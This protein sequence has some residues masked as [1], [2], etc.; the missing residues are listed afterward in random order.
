AAPGG[1]SLSRHRQ[2]LAPAR[3]AVE[4]V[5][6]ALLKG[7]DP[8]PQKHEGCPRC[9]GAPAEPDFDQLLAVAAL[10][11]EEIHAAGGAPLGG[12]GPP[13]PQPHAR[14]RLMW[15]PACTRLVPAG[16]YP[17]S[18]RSIMH[19]GTT[20]PEDAPHG[21]LVNLRDQAL[22]KLVRLSTGHTE[23]EGRWLR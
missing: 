6:R 1:G 2:A 10:T 7:L 20:A 16:H 23:A 3:P 13:P 11:G 21:L 9:G 5:R 18:W 19:E 8:A 15:C 22:V 4:A 14:A 12:L 17:A